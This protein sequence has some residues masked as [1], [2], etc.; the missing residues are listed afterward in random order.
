M[1]PKFLQS[2]NWGNRDCVAEAHRLM[3]QW[4]PPMEHVHWLQLLDARFPDYKV[5]AT[6]L[7]SCR[8]MGGGRG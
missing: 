8:V 2:V 1:L 3:V 6:T 7:I 4:A 5:R